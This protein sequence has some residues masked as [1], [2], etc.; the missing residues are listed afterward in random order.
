[1]LKTQGPFPSDSDPGLKKRLCA[2][3]LKEREVIDSKKSREKID[4]LRVY[5]KEAAS[6]KK[7]GYAY[8]T[9][10][11]ESGK[12]HRKK[13]VESRNCSLRHILLHMA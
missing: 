4:D 13:H 11:T 7:A 8:S 5:K 3:R 10:A 9:K 1:M 6:N 2:Q 12:E